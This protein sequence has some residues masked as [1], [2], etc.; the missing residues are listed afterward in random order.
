MGGA[1]GCSSRRRRLLADTSVREEQ[2]AGWMV[3]LRAAKLDPNQRI[4]YQ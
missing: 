4:R 2:D 1:S 3:G